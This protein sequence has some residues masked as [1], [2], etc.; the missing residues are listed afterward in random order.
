[1]SSILILFFFNLWEGATDTLPPPP[2]FLPAPMVLNQMNI[3]VK[4]DMNIP[5]ETTAHCLCHIL[6]TH[7][8]YGMLKGQ[9]LLI[10]GDEDNE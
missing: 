3:F 2:P 10:F 4:Q 9:D 1:V 5:L 8:I 6:G 7:D